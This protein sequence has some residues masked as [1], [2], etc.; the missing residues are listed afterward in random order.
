MAVIKRLIFA[1]L[2]Q[3][4]YINLRCAKDCYITL[5]TESY[6]RFLIKFLLPILILVGFTKEDIKSSIGL[7]NLLLRQVRTIRKHVGF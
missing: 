5:F 6:I 3:E 2:N 4:T 1:I 7:E